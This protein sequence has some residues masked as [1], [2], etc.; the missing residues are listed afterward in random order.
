MFNRL[1]KAKVNIF[2][3]HPY[4]LLNDFKILMK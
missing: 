2:F 4:L 1:S 3:R